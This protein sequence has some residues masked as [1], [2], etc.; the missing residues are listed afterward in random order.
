M[1]GGI[2]ARLTHAAKYEIRAGDLVRFLGIRVPPGN[3]VETV[4][5]LVAGESGRRINVDPDQT[6]VI[7]VTWEDEEE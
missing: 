6:L 3:S 1:D 5:H 4:M 7:Q 2:S